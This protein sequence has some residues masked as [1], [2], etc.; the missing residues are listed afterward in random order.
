[1]EPY[2]EVRLKGE[3]TRFG[4]VEEAWSFASELSKHRKFGTTRK[5]VYVRK[6]GMLTVESDV[7]ENDAEVLDASETGEIDWEKGAWF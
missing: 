1:M 6:I 2:W 4:S 3:A 7:T 5:I